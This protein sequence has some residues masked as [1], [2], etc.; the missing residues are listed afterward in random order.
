[1]EESEGEARL[2]NLRASVDAVVDRQK[3]LNQAS[4]KR[5]KK[6]ETASYVAVGL[7]G[8]VVLLVLIYLLRRLFF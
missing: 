1:M 7:L 6:I 5:K 2:R 8:L 4:G 3:S